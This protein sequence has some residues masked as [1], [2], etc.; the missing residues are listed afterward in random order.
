MTQEHTFSVA[1]LADKILQRT[2]LG[3]LLMAIAFAIGAGVHVVSDDTARLL[4]KIQLVF[5]ALAVISIIP[6]FVRYIRLQIKG[7]CEFDET[8]S[9]IGIVFNK[10]G[11]R[12]FGASF[13]MLAIAGPIGRK[14]L[15]DLPAEFFDYVIL[16]VSLAVFGITFFASIERDD[17]E[18]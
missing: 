10:A 5:V 18:D 2:A 1:Q 17:G 8:Q 3:V 13:L 9:Y 11:I 4:D 15:P 6:T 16:A 7:A 14:H 12:A